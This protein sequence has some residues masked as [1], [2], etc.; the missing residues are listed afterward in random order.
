MA[1]LTAKQTELTAAKTALENARVALSYGIGD[2]QIAREGVIVLEQSVARI[3][4][5]IDELTAA[6][7]GAK[8]P[9]FITPTWSP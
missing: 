6:A 3:Q 2:R 7:A 8:N 5:E 4:R 1:T 9:I